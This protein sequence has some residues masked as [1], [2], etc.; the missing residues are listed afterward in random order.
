MSTKTP[1]ELRSEIVETRRQLQR[2]D[3]TETRVANLRHDCS[4]AVERLRRKTDWTRQ[5]RQLRDALD[6]FLDPEGRVSQEITDRSREYADE[7]QA[8]QFV[9]EYLAEEFEFLRGSYVGEPGNRQ[10]AFAA[11]R[12]RT[13]VESPWLTKFVDDLEAFVNGQSYDENHRQSIRNSFEKAIEE[14]FPTPDRLLAFVDIVLEAARNYRADLR[15]T[16]NTTW[17]DDGSASPGLIQQFLDRS[18]DESIDPASFLEDHPVALLPVRVETR[19]VTDETP[20]LNESAQRDSQLRI[21]V[22]PDDLHVDT[23]EPELTADE[24]RLGKFFWAKLWICSHPDPVA[25]MEPPSGDQDRVSLL[26]ESRL[27]NHVNAVVD[28]HEFQSG[29]KLY[30]EVKERSWRRLVERLGRERAAWVVHRLAPKPVDRNEVAG[31]LLSGWRRVEVSADGGSDQD[32]DSVDFRDQLNVDG[33]RYERG[34]SDF[35]AEGPF[36]GGTRFGNGFEL[37]ESVREAIRRGS[38]SG[39]A[40]VQYEDRAQWSTNDAVPLLAFPTVEN[41][42]DTWTKQPRAELLP[43][44]WVVYGWIDESETGPEA[45]GNGTSD[46]ESLSPGN[47]DGESR[48]DPRVPEWARKRVSETTSFTEKYGSLIDAEGDGADGRLDPDRFRP[49]SENAKTGGPPNAPGTTFSTGGRAPDLVTSGSA[50]REP[51][52]LGPDPKQAGDHDAPAT[53]GTAAQAPHG[54]EW[55]ADFAEAERAGMALRVTAS[56]LGGRDPTDV[57]FDRL[58]V[59]GVK[60]TMSEEQ[61]T[62]GLRALFEAHHYTDGLEFLEHGT[63]TSNTDEDSAYSRRDAPEES[64]AVECGDPLSGFGDDARPE[65]GSRV[66]TDGDV[67]ARALGIA[68]PDED[69]HDHPF[70]HVENAG[71]VNQA[72]QWHANAA[73]WD[74]TIGYYLRNVLLSNRWT[75]EGSVW[76]DS[77]HPGPYRNLAEAGAFFEDP[78]GELGDSLIWEDEIRR[79]FVQYVRP[80]GPLPTIRAGNQPY[81]ILPVTDVDRVA[82]GSVKNLI[83]TL[84]GPF[85]KAADDLVNISDE[86]LGDEGTRQTIRS[87]LQ[88][89][90]NGS[91]YDAR[92]MW[93]GT[94]AD[95][96][97]RRGLTDALWENGLV[98]LDR[99]APSLDP[100]LGW[101]PPRDSST[102]TT[103]DRAGRDLVG[104]TD[105]DFLAV[106]ANDRFDTF[107]TMGYDPGFD[108][109]TVDGE[110]LPDA[111]K[112]SIWAGYGDEQLLF[113]ALTRAT[114]GQWQDIAMRGGVSWDD[115][116]VNPHD[117][118]A[119]G[120]AEPYVHV[121]YQLWDLYDEYGDPGTLHTLLRQLAR[122]SLLQ[123]YVGDRLRLGL[124]TG[125]LPALT[126]ESVLQQP[127]PEKYVTGGT[128]LYDLLTDTRH[129]QNVRFV[130]Y[131]EGNDNY[132]NVDVR[133][134]LAFLST[135]PPSKLR[136]LVTETLSLAT[137]RF[138]AW[139]TSLATE[140][141]VENR[142]YG[143]DLRFEDKLNV[144]EEEGEGYYD[145]N[146]SGTDRDTG[147]ED[148]GFE[149]GTR[150]FVGGYGFVENLSPDV[151]TG[152]SGGRDADGE[153]TEFTQGPSVQHATTAALLRG[154]HEHLG[155]SDQLAVDFSAG[156]VSKAQQILQGLKHGQRLGSLLGYRFE[157]YVKEHTDGSD[158]QYLDEYRKAFPAVAGELDHDGSGST[159]SATDDARFDVTDGYRLFHAYREAGTATAFFSSHSVTRTTTFE[160]A[161]LELVATVDAVRDLLLAEDVHQ[162][163]KG[164]FERAGWSLDG[165][166]QGQGVPD[167]DVLRTPRTGTDVSHKA[168]TLFGDPEA[169]KTPNVWQVSEPVVKPDSLPTM[170][171]VAGEPTRVGD[172]VDAATA[173][174]ADPG[175][176]V[177]AGDAAN[178]RVDAAENLDAWVGE[179]LP[180]PATV[181]SPSEFQ[182]TNDRGAA[183]GTFKTPTRPAKVSVTDLEFEPDLVVFTASTAV[184]NG[185][186]ESTGDGFA[187][188]SHGV[189]AR[190]R[191]G[192]GG[193]DVEE[194]AV[195]VVAGPNDTSAARSNDRAISLVRHDAQGST[196]RTV[197]TLS[198]TTDDGFELSFTTAESEDPVLVEYLAMATGAVGSVDVGHFQTPGSAATHSEPLSV[199]A[200]HAMLALGSP[201]AP[202]FAHGQAV[203]TDAGITQLGLGGTTAPGSQNRIGVRTD[204]AVHL[205]LGDGSVT[206]GSVTNLGATLDVEFGNPPDGAS[207]ADPGGVCTYVAF[208]TPETVAAPTVGVLSEGHNDLG[209]EPGAV[210]LVGLSGIDG[211]GISM[212]GSE[213]GTTAGATTATAAAG[214]SHGLAVGD[215]GQR[216]FG[217]TVRSD[218]NHHVGAGASNAAVVLPSV[219]PTGTVTG[220]TV[221]RITDTDDS[222]FTASFTEGAATDC[223]VRFVAWPAAPEKLTHEVQT[224][225]TV[226][227]LDLAPVDLLYAAQTETD[228]AQSQLEQRIGYHLFRTR[229]S[230]DAT[231]PVPDDAAIQ[232]TF[233]ETA[234]GAAVTVA[235]LLEVLRAVREL[236]FDGRAVDADDLVHPSEAQ[237]PGYTEPPANQ[238][239]GNS[240]DAPELTTVGDLRRR[241]LAGSTALRSVRETVYNRV[242]ALSAPDDEQALTEHVAELRDAAQAFDDSVPLDALDR[243]TSTVDDDGVAAVLNDP[244]V[245]ALGK[246]L[247]GSRTILSGDVDDGGDLL[248]WELETF[249]RFLPAGPATAATADKATTVRAL[250]DQRIRGSTEVDGKAE[251]DVHVWPR[252]PGSTFA[253]RTV[254]GVVTDNQGR[255]E[256]TLDFDGARSGEELAVVA[257]YQQS[258]EP[259]EQ[260]G[261]GDQSGEDGGTSQDL[262]IVHLSSV[263]SREEYESYAPSR[264]R[265]VVLSMASEMTDAAAVVETQYV[266]GEGRPTEDNG[267]VAGVRVTLSARD[268]E[269]D[270]GDRSVVVSVGPH[271]REIELPFDVGG[272]DEL[273]GSRGSEWIVSRAGEGVRTSGSTVEP[274]LTDVGGRFFDTGDGGDGD[275]T[276]TGTDA[277]G[278][279]VSGGQSGFSDLGEVLEDRDFSILETLA[280]RLGAGSVDDLVPVMPTTEFFS[281]GDVVYS[282][283]ARVLR[284]DADVVAEVD[285]DRTA[286]TSVDVE[287]L[288]DE[289]QGTT[290]TVAA[291]RSDG[292]TIDS[293]DV[294][295]VDGGE[296][297]ATLSISGVAPR[298][299]FTVDVSAGG[300][301]VREF[302]GCTV[303]P[304]DR[305]TPTGV[306]ADLTL[307]PVLLWIDREAEAIGPAGANADGGSGD[308]ETGDGSAGGAEAVNLDGTPGERLRDA[309]RSVDWSR[310]AGSDGELAAMASLKSALDADPDAENPTLSTDVVGAVRT[311][312]AP[313]ESG[314]KAI[315]N[316]DPLECYTTLDRLVEPLAAVRVTDLFDAL[317]TPVTASEMRFWQRPGG[318]L[319]G[320][321]AGVGHA[322]ENPEILIG[323]RDAVDYAFAPAF[324]AHLED[325]G[326]FTA[327][328]AA[329]FA[330]YLREFLSAPP[331]LVTELDGT[332]ADPHEFLRQFGALAYEP[333]TFVADATPST[334]SSRLGTVANAVGSIS[335]LGEH[336]SLSATPPGASPSGRPSTEVTLGGGSPIRPSASSVTIAPDEEE[337]EVVLSNQLSSPMTVSTGISGDASNNLV[338]SGDPLVTVGANAT[339][340][341]EIAVLLPTSGAVTGSIDLS[342]PQS[343][344]A[345]SVD[346]TVPAVGIGSGSGSGR[347]PLS[348]FASL[349][350][351]FHS[352]ALSGYVSAIQSGTHG[353]L[354]VPTTARSSYGDRYDGWIATAATT[355]ADANER[356]NAALLVHPFDEALRIGMCEPLR[357]GLLRASTLGVY[358]GTPQSATGGRRAD[359]ETLVTQ[360][361]AVLME[362]DDRFAAAEAALG[363]FGPL[364]ST[365]EKV[366]TLT[367][368]LQAVFGEEFAVHPLFEA[369]NAAE[370]QATFAN[371]LL[372][373][374]DPLAA[375]TTIGR[376]ARIRDRPAVFREAYSYGEVLTGTPMWNLDVGQLPHRPDDEWMGLA[377]AASSTGRQSVLAQLETGLATAGS[378][379]GAGPMA[380]VYVDGWSETIP[381]DTQITGVAVNY[382][383]PDST[384]PNAVLLAV[385]PTDDRWSWSV[386][387]VREMVVDATETMKIRMVDPEAARD[388]LGELLPAVWLPNTDEAKPSSPSVDLSLLDH[389]GW[390]SYRRQQGI[391]VLLWALRADGPLVGLSDVGTAVNFTSSSLSTVGTNTSP[392]NY[393]G[394][395]R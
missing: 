362:I 178:P 393:G 41:R 121:Y 171:N 236:V 34:P 222:G 198:R 54:M 104:H 187:G 10:T 316:L 158:L 284:P 357:R 261:D 317:G 169:A 240:T 338:V 199:D 123:T 154:A 190:T 375:E 203:A 331:W 135:L 276:V 395:I 295:A 141:L 185:E 114:K 172:V 218:G 179:F 275:E 241:L 110:A 130:D 9:D 75:D 3:R 52:T 16:L 99:Y 307:L 8:A 346:V 192:S 69:P 11:F 126:R 22:Y 223:V 341:I 385:P 38:A 237:G 13:T 278:G 27:R 372:P 78:K 80:Q 301:V 162:L 116:T 166:A 73:L 193:I 129:N 291:T 246:H 381:D 293:T 157:R 366:A 343:G 394:E 217:T 4:D 321:Q 60:A 322:V 55:T 329:A 96:D 216:S 42:P 319:A 371:D 31:K 323:E 115:D 182:W 177:P 87:I 6:G 235:E 58:V 377:E 120:T 384:A 379:V 65:F 344:A 30:E 282:S 213:Q 197:A 304:D 234:D 296:F 53:E 74:G 161:L 368:A 365:E 390:E 334:F 151:G 112:P 97:W 283:M 39:E 168:M 72:A 336:L 238:S 349:L 140:R 221:C 181:G 184:S 28:P 251:V 355:T 345:A 330:H 93:Q 50:I 156:R 64:L 194:S 33:E 206:S 66:P 124:E 70:A 302:E 32:D 211:T 389:D 268:G 242:T 239:E 215:G 210:S 320:V 281:P 145:G 51:L 369:H 160:D 392:G 35:G 105:D 252:S 165:L 274:D 77:E 224:N 67:L 279:D 183:Q 226:D 186:G 225:V 337:F 359:V 230:V 260:S 176:S 328:E 247:P 89:E 342:I 257:V 148:F 47:A 271:E 21:R 277:T 243:L 383:A 12:N 232:L 109:L 61:S 57:A 205:P 146:V 347:D 92:E 101:L 85:E 333:E 175:D 350:S 200:D 244:S 37:S 17:D 272:I 91:S 191:D 167:L 311:I 327:N 298:T 256:T 26:P 204:R 228:A 267:R 378:A 352:S 76:D 128:G 248:L 24:E 208:E 335:D 202:G 376:I 391:A 273:D 312:T 15:A 18:D 262:G 144:F 297:A 299:R 382:D 201:G 83:T 132:R 125:D 270:R 46:S 188:W 340:R 306:L 63:P 150:T 348:E 14:E 102:P 386:P 318:D 106:L 23:H 253:D 266:D 245:A 5:K 159:R 88:R 367:D 315:Q 280:P 143:T 113:Y 20:L 82:G 127:I 285:P 324:K 370:L 363:R 364:D 259:S 314:A 289:S 131:V 214:L 43:D 231:Y 196:E 136:Q 250:T 7:A 300:T 81:G 212:G 305:R 79:H 68:S 351:T 118:I 107:R 173:L 207:L 94:E 220:T 174:P 332:V 254:T 258:R 308:A 134:S 292:T 286:T 117:E 374:D 149:E 45:S 189:A 227:E 290:L 380:G 164:N 180:D 229:S 25:A 325:S 309:I 264:R 29:S 294:Q 90:A 287:G 49:R 100:R 133:H 111:L 84:R 326:A 86:R 170:P 119:E 122:F 339:R 209:F 59:V 44:R 152:E 155:E 255:F 153:I 387:D 361:E 103:I 373:A 249:G 269:I 288:T 310:I 62:T 263:L 353:T 36:A 195:G 108:D 98:G 265:K 303:S 137:H 356:V 354:P 142:S 360:G 147:A 139:W 56:D 1:S 313:D 388:H 48:F 219:D 358:G 71:A 40:Q 138:D 163:G 233:T 19:Y 95:V 2:A